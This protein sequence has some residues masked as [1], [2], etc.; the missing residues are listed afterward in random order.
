MAR[1]W[2]GGGADDNWNTAANWFPAAI[3]G[4]ADS[5]TLD[6]TSSDPV[7]INVNA[8]VQGLTIAS[9]YGGTITQNAGVTLTVGV[10]GYS[11]AGSSF[12]GGNAA[13]TV[14]GP[15][16]LTGGTF[17]STSGT[18]T[19]TGGFTVNGG[20]FVHGG[21]TTLLSS[22]NATVS[23][24]SGVTFNALTVNSSGTK[25]LNDTITVTGTLDLVAGSLNTGTIAARGPINQQVGFN[26][27]NSATLLIDGGSGQTF[28]GLANTTTTTL[29]NVVIAKTG[30][31]TLT[32][33]GTIRTARN[34]TYT[35][36]V[37][38]PTTSTLIVAGGIVSGSQPLTNL[39]IRGN[40]TVA[41]GTT[42]TASGTFTMPTAVT[43]T[44]DGTITAAG[45]TSLTDGTLNGTGTLAARGDISQASTYDGGAATLL[46][47]GGSGQTFS[48][49][50]VVGA[51][52]LPNV[53]IAKTGGSTLTLSGTI[54]TARNWTYTTGV[55][56]PSG[57]TLYLAGTQTVSGS[58]P[59]D[60]LDIRGTVTQG[61]ADTITVSGT[62]NLFS[63]S[64]NTGTIAARGPINQQVGFNGTNSAT[65]LIDGGSG[66]T[67][68]GLA[69]TTTTT[70]PNV[71]IAK[72]GGSTLTLSGTIRTARN[73]TYTTGVIAPSGSTLYL[74]GTQTVSGSFPL[75]GLDIRGTVTQG[76]ADTITVSGT[77]NLFSGSLNTGTIAAR[78]PINQQV[79]FNGTNSATLLIDGGSGQTFSGLANTTTTTLPNV[80]IAKTGGSTLTLSGTIRTARNWTY[81]TGVIAPSGSTLVL[82]GTQTV[83][84]SFGL[85]NLWLNGGGS[86][87][88]TGTVTAAG[89]VTLS[90][91]T[92]DS[93]TVI[94]HGDIAQGAG[95][96]GGTGTLRIEGPGPQ[97][98]SGSAGTTGQLP[99]VVID[100]PSTLTLSGT[101]RT[102]RNWT[103]TTG[104]IAPSG[105]TLVLV[106]TQTVAGSFGLDNLWLNGGGSK[107]F[108]GTVTAAGTVTLSDGTLDSGT[109]IAHGDIAQGAGSDGGTGTLRIEGP[110]P[111]TFSGSA[112]TT[113]QLPNVV[114][115]TPSTLTL[116]GTIRTAR[117]WTY[118][119]GVIAPSGSTLVLVG[120]QTVAGS[121][122]LD[123]LWLN[124]GG[125]K[126]FTGTVTAAGTVTL[127]DGTLDSGTV[128]AHGDIAQ[129]AGSDGGTGTL[130]IEGPGPQ[131]F[132]GSAGTTGQ[133]PNVVIDTPSTL[134][135]S[136]TIRTARNWT[137]TTGVIAPSGSTLVLVGTQ[138]VS[139]SF[140]LA[141]LTFGAAGAKTFTG[142]VAVGGLLTLT[143]GSIET[144]TVAA[145]GDIIEGAS[146][147]GGSGILLIEGPGPQ[148]F[149]GNVA[150][151]LPDV[152][153]D[154]PG[155]L[156]LVGTIRTT[157]DWT[158][159]AGTL[160]PGTS[161]LLFD[162]TQ[163]INGTFGLANVTFNNAGA[164]TVTG[165][166][167]VGGLL[168]LTNGLINGGTVA[169]AGDIIEGASFDGGSGIL[170]IEGPG[171][172]TFTG[173]V[174]GTLP[175]VV[176]D[177][178]GTLSLVG[179]IRTTNDWTYTAGTLA[180]GTS[181]LLFDGTQAINGT[182]GLANVTF[183]NA[184]AKT[185][186]G[187]VTVGGLLTL[188]NGLI[189]GGTV[190]A[191]G[192]IIE[193]ASFDGGSG[194][195]LIEGPGPQTFTGNV[196]GTLPDVVIDTPGTLSLVGTI[197]TTNDWTYTAGTLAPGTS[198]LLFDGTQAINGT[199]GLANVTFNNAG[200][201]TVT[202]T[203]TVGGLLTLT[204]G[205]INGGTVA[206]AGD[207]IEGASF[208]G[209]S[210]ILLIEGPGPQTFTGNVAG[211]LPDVVIDTP[212]TLSLVG[213]IRTTNDWTYTAG[214]LA[215][216]TS[217]LLFDG[218][219]TVG[220]V[221]VM[222]AFDVDVTTGTV[223]WDVAL[224]LGGDL[225]V[226][227][228]TFA[229]SAAGLPVSIDGD[230][231]VAGTLDLGAS[232]ITV[233]G[234][235]TV[236][237]TLDSPL[238]GLI[239][240][241]SAPQ[242]IGGTSP[243]TIGLLT[244]DNAAGVAMATD[245]AAMGGVDFVAGQLAVGS[246]ALTIGGLLTGATS[247]LDVG[248]SSTLVITGTTPGI[249]LPSVVAT[250]G[251][252]RVSNPNGAELSGP[253]AI[254]TLLDL[255]DGVVLPTSGSVTVLPGG[256]VTRTAGHVAGA[257]RLP[258]SQGF[259]VTIRFDVGDATTYA[260]VT[261]TFDVVT[262]DG[263]IVVSSVAGDHPVPGKPIDISNSVNRHWTVV[264]EGVGFGS[265]S[266]TLAWVAGDIDIG[267]DP[268]KFIV[269]KLDGSTWT[270]PSSGAA[271]ATSISAYGL[272]SFS[273]FAVGE[274]LPALAPPETS[275]GPVADLPRG[276]LAGGSSEVSSRLAALG[277]AAVLAFLA[278]G[279]RSTRPRRRSPASRPEDR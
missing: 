232:T 92:L 79:G 218:T 90:D 14:N 242:L 24:P 202:G 77:L 96:D 115:D 145:A 187:T 54:R 278:F 19:V 201:K 53:V 176:I 267:A 87:T 82:V 28:S 200:A 100:T 240:S 160:A 211:T 105:S 139:G 221:G 181:T 137:Y 238:G 241:G 266:I 258:I 13:I 191:A 269:A 148:T 156:S 27:T 18:L 272:S 72:T 168:T 63:G 149:T 250:V 172:Q 131:T 59:L 147:D 3:P 182:F 10:V 99:N 152:V 270:V 193:G 188:T 233:A 230:L 21:G 146:F 61:A 199:F 6:A 186:T 47:D 126:T 143:D 140:P 128:I 64:L 26:G 120:T 33:S 264:N 16:S 12:A 265:Y 262:V 189:N 29:P 1:T 5:L 183:N 184:G 203:V 219:L 34:W 119:T 74:A 35:T 177:T 45:L 58:F 113:G 116:S 197:R 244:V 69:N 25:T 173:N 97:T 274:E 66:Q 98:F 2:T 166:V 223:T 159:T 89:T 127:S 71:V 175:D 141:N 17:T 171:P 15:F 268:S 279:Q 273:D 254:S 256:T 9:T 51:G 118:T 4:A 263:S 190:A 132:S 36:G 67:F 57:S 257:L 195:L 212:G 83:A 110:G 185:V 158:Y 80:V 198:T 276:P 204:N 133:L 192:D 222:S 37:I 196:A 144:G 239:L 114:I 124:G 209:G 95:S 103:Y 153:I 60:G 88:F 86:K 48:G 107:T 85:D 106:G 161:T 31:S 68:S 248:S 42:I 227:S 220:G 62:L 150:G 123:N 277:L 246:H 249:V 224:A 205:L 215:P 235:V 130:R 11:Q 179:T 46:I 271:T 275:V 125:S 207:I 178:P 20:S 217:T 75:D 261:L 40:T 39:E 122:G 109:V 234:D 225:D 213:T 247:G 78:G 164:K 93:G 44:L 170:L 135:L 157:N 251:T 38:D 229:S 55:I 70:L 180:P 259:G 52:L 117:N 194:I 129:G 245:L 151:T 108:T 208:D 41:A 50:L 56:D 65:L 23:T 253:I 252:L 154:T 32:L 226:I 214:T 255:A 169:A 162:G 49:P 121:F 112:G 30:G 237:G 104:V 142:T 22:G 73:W 167:T 155:T 136:G 163:A 43:L 94:A 8:N 216:G 210:G 102:A 111:Q 236:N 91:G 134:T 81:T 7:V 165:T 84:G 138:T 231:T 243:I 174:A 101:I 260:P 228:G 76:A 206:A